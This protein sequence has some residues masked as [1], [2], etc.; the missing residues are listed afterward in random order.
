MGEGLQRARYRDHYRLLPCLAITF[1]GVLRALDD[2]QPAVAHFG[3]HGSPAGDLIL[4]DLHRGE[5]HIPPE[6]LASLLELL[7]ARPWL[8]VFAACHSVRLARAAVR[9]A[10][11][12]IG[13][14]GPLGD[15]TALLFSATLYERLASRREPDVPRAFAL[16]RLACIAA[17]HE[18]ASL[19][20]LFAHPLQEGHGE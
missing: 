7:D 16:A 5:H 6:R 15:D 19:A 18:D 10:H 13:F 4:Q 11:Y 9:H 3:G 8:M 2:H 1:S 14:K 20:C 12:A 17:G